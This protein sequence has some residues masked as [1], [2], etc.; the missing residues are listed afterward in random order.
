ML[1]VLLHYSMEKGYKCRIYRGLQRCCE[2]T[3]NLCVFPFNITLNTRNLLI[4]KTLTRIDIFFNF[5]NTLLQNVLQ[6]KLK[7]CV[8]PKQKT[9]FFD[10]LQTCYNVTTNVYKGVQYGM[11]QKTI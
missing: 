5:Q 3:E 11:F 1:Q 6:N 9:P 8:T 7:M 4:Y 10:F 2:R